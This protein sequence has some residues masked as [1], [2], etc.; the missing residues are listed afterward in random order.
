MNTITK[1][2]IV[3]EIVLLKNRIKTLNLLVKP[4]NYNKNKKGSNYLKKSF[5]N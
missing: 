5:T 3:N 4:K 1:K 2:E